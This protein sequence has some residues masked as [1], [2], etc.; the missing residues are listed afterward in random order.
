MAQR[1][2][3]QTIN[4]ILIMKKLLI[5][6]LLIGMAAGAFCQDRTEILISQVPGINSDTTVTWNNGSRQDFQD[7]IF[8]YCV[9]CDSAWVKL[10]ISDFGSRW[11]TVPLWDGSAYVDSVFMNGTV[12]RTIRLA[13]TPV[14]FEKLTW[15]QVGGTKPSLRYASHTPKE[16]K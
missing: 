11:V 12:S 6:G 14:D 16:N 8:L 13:H 5:I 7:G 10:Q 15:N 1:I 2:G 4:N 9:A 3:K